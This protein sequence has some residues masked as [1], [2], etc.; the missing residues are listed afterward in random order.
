MPKIVDHDERRRDVLTAAT[1]V[2]VRDGIDA[3]T[4][5]AIAKEAGLSNGVL[6]HYFADK[7]EI[8]LSALRQ[9]HERIRQRLIRKVEG[10]SGLVALRT[11]LLDNLPLDDERAEETRL[12]ISF[13]SRSLAADALAEVQRTEAGEL[14]AAVHG[15]LARA[16]TDGEVRRE[17]DLDDATETLLALVDGL[18]LHLVLYPHRLTRVSVE[19]L[20]LAALSG[21]AS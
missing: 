3:A 9:S 11:V 15:L 21:L 14:R 18:S 7:D 16:R 4:T 10:A 1:R 8:L 17:T 19:R 13:W 12:E 20:M 2:I 6:S 5:R